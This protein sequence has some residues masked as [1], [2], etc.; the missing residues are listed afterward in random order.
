MSAE[1]LN[2]D[3]CY[4]QGIIEIFTEAEESL[5][6]YLSGWLARKCGICRECQDVLSKRLDEHSYC[7]RPDDAFASVEICRF[8]FGWSNRAKHRVFFTAVHVME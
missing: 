4:E 5:I 6:N 1:V 2:S 7:R 3:I 8:V